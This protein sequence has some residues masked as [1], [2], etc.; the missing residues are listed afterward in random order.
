[1]FVLCETS[2]GET[3]MMTIL[4]ASLTVMMCAAVLPRRQSDP[5]TTVQA[6]SPRFHHTLTANAAVT[7]PKL[8]Q[9]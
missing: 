7:T 2:L 4:G 3:L 5:Q 9:R 1:M 6:K 8:I